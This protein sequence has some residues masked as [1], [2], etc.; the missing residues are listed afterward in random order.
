M[1][2]SSVRPSGLLHVELVG[3]SGDELRGVGDVGQRDERNSVEELMRE[4]PTEFDHDTC[5]PD[6]ARARD[7]D[8]P[9]LAHQ[10]DE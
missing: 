5:L 1:P 4:R 7:R 6:T 9:M 10:P 8:D 2:S 3:E